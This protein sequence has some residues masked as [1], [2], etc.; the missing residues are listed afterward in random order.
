MWIIHFACVLW[1]YSGACPNQN[2]VNTFEHR[3]F[4]DNGLPSGNAALFNLLNPYLLHLAQ[5]FPHVSS[6]HK[7]KYIPIACHVLFW[8]VCVTGWEV[9]ISVN[10]EGIHIKKCC[11]LTAAHWHAVWLSKSISPAQTLLLSLSDVT[12]GT[13]KLPVSFQKLHV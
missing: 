13:R 9:H 7:V 4:K 6:W 5:N 12:Q 8:K 10:T 3:I 1:P 2:L 11:H